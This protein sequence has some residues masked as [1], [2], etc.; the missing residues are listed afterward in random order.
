[1]R[2]HLQLPRLASCL[3]WPIAKSGFIDAKAMR[4]RDQKGLL[5]RTH[6]FLALG[7]TLHGR[8]ELLAYRIFYRGE[9]S[10]PPSSVTCASISISTWPSRNTRRKSLPISVPPTPSKASTTPSKPSSAM[11]AAS[12]IPNAKPP[13]KS[14]SSSTASN[15]QLALSPADASPPTSA[16]ASA[17]S[18]TSTNPNSLQPPYTRSLTTTTET[19]LHY[20][21]TPSLSA[22]SFTIK[23]RALRL[24]NAL[25]RATGRVCF[26][27]PL[28]R[29]LGICH[30]RADWEN[31][32][33]FA[34][35]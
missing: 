18:K 10:L 34:I 32:G 2:I 20:P 19:V 33:L 4:V 3:F 8:K 15:D 24:R 35:L 23:D 14:G 7:I 28:R 9:F 30:T 11:P 17:I 21:P 26:A 31:W 29:A 22:H 25:L 5:V 16:N 12:S 1:M 27:A 6:A 13:S